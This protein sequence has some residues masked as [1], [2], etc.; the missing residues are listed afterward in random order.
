MQNPGGS[1]G[2]AMPPA[3]EERKPVGPIIGVVIIILLLILGGLYVW[4]EKLNSENAMT[5]DEI[6]NAAD[7]SVANLQAQ[8]TSDDISSIKADTDATNLEGLDKEVSDIEKA[9]GQ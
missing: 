5:P 3:K 4:G 7:A 2:S 6:R 1:M 9:L 8:G